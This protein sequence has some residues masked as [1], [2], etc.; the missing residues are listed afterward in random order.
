[1]SSAQSAQSAY[2]TVLSN[3]SILTL[4][5]VGETT[6]YCVAN[7]PGCVPRTSTQAITNATLPYTLELANHGTAALL[8]NPELLKGLN[9][10]QG[11]CT[12]R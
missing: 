1:M 2:C 10:I 9:L 12:Y 5:Q 4:L 11:M 8:T 7:M 3:A 6:M